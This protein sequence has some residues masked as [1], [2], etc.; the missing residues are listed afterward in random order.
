L[1]AYAALLLGYGERELALA[2]AQGELSGLVLEAEG[3]DV[4]K[5]RV[6]YPRHRA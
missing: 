2:V 6:R 4:P 3:E 1:Q 5:S